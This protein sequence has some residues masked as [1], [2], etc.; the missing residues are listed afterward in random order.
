LGKKDGGPGKDRKAA[1]AKAGKRKRYLAFGDE[2]RTHDGPLAFSRVK[3]V[4]VS[5]AAWREKHKKA[6]DGTEDWKSPQDTHNRDHQPETDP[7]RKR[8]VV[9]YQY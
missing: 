6:I 4:Q 2:A 1:S 8:M 7:D 9:T 3:R 5:M